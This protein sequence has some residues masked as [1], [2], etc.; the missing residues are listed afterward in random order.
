MVNSLGIRVETAPSNIS[1]RWVGLAPFRL[2]QYHAVMVIHPN[3]MLHGDNYSSILR[4]SARG[5]FLSSA[6]PD[7]PLEERLIAFPPSRKMF[8]AVLQFSQK[9]TYSDYSGWDHAGWYPAHG[10]PNSPLAG[11]L[12]TFIAANGQGLMSP[13]STAMYAK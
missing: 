3:V 13:T 5:K 11:L 4:C 9:A 2:V 1:H 8:D 6:G 10:K 12:W 7:F